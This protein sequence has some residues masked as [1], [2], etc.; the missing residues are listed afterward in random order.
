MNEHKSHISR[1]ALTLIAAGVLL[2]LIYHT[3]RQLGVGKIGEPTDIGGGFIVLGGYVI[4]GVGIIMLVV[5]ILR[6]HSD[7]PS[8]P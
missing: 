1:L 5:S 3:L 7:P 4:G 2:V 8:S 6:G